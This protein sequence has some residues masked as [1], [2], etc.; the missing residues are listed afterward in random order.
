MIIVVLNQAY[1]LEVA[2]HLKDTI[3]LALRAPKQ[4]LAV[5]PTKFSKETG[6]GFLMQQCI[7]R[8]SDFNLN[9]ANQFAPQ[10]N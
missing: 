4:N 8:S 2:S 9:L 1:I 10:R 5:D 7:Q 6:K 3:L